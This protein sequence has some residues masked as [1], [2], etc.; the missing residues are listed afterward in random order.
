[1]H[2]G[3]KSF[4][5]SWNNNYPLDKWFRAKYG[6]PFNSEKHRETNPLDIYLEWAEDRLF[7]QYDTED[8]INKEETAEYKKGVWLKPNG[9]Y[10]KVEMTE[11][12]FD[13]FDI[14]LI[15]KSL[16]DVSSESE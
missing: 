4:V 12:E 13:N 2:P 16:N 15:N 9:K 1:M 10:G 7:D 8:K 6:I 3:I 14:S 11:A 5:V